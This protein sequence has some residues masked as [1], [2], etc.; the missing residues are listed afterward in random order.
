MAFVLNFFYVTLDIEVTDASPL[1]IELLDLAL[2]YLD[3]DNPEEIYESNGLIWCGIKIFSK[4]IYEIFSE[5]DRTFIS[6]DKKALEN[7][8]KEISSNLEYDG[9]TYILKDGK[10]SVASPEESFVLTAAISRTEN[11]KMGRKSYFE[12][13]SSIYDILRQYTIK[14]YSDHEYTQLYTIRKDN[15]YDEDDEEIIIS[16]NKEELENFARR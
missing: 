1:D 9:E 15:K 8:C 6:R 4:E 13:I 7:F 12:K 3:H 11:F 10:V 5:D 2:C 16:R 14:I